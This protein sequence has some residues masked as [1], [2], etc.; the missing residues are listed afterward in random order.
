M[1]PHILGGILVSPEATGAAELLDGVALALGAAV[2]LAIAAVV[3]SCAV[4]VAGVQPAISQDEKETNIAAARSKRMAELLASRIGDVEWHRPRPP[5]GPG[6]CP[7]SQAS[8][9]PKLDSGKY[10]CGGP[11]VDQ[12]VPL[13]ITLSECEG[14]VCELSADADEAA[15]N[16]L[17]ARFGLLSETLKKRYGQQFERKTRELEGCADGLQ[18]CFAAGRARTSIAWR[19][20][21]RQVVSLEL[22]GGQSG[23]PTLVLHYGTSEPV[24]PT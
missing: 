13:K 19:W 11:A 24:P 23:K 6:T 16:V 9:A 22:D 2:A 17:V 8:T 14:L 10:T 7:I 4:G 20:A 1:P 12:G 5:Y 3:G 15:W 18:R 21:N